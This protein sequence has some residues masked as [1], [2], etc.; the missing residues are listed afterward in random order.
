MTQ[1]LCKSSGY[2]EFPDLFGGL[3][4]SISEEAFNLFGFSV[5]WYGLLIGIG[6]L[7]CVAL[8][9]RSCRRYGIE[10][11]DLLDYALFCLPAA[12]L[13]A[14]IY[15]VLFQWNAFK[16]DLVRVFYIWEGGL[17]VYGGILAAVLAA[18]LVS[19]YKKKSFLKLV[20][21]AAPYI[22]LG[23]AIGRWGNFFNQEAYGGATTLPWGMTGNQIAVENIY[24]GWRADTLVHP[25][26]LY[27]SLWCFLGFALIM[28]YRRSKYKKVDGECICLYMVLYGVERT[29]VEGLRTDSLYI[30]STGIRV[31]QLLSIVLV[32]AGIALFIVL[33][34]RYNKKQA[35]EG[36]LD[37]EQ[38]TGFESVKERLDA[39]E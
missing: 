8:G 3:K 29:L 27:E 4:F 10:Q 16:D 39:E 12:I 19:R 18:F 9:M 13:G 32:L 7:L 11:D 2:V 5:R 6:V 17:A 35:L 14:R 28:L 24:R 20:D 23:Q 15:Y 25:T 1:L 30:G 22:L 38:K 37:P 34:M 21:F 33:R 31:S 36:A 26:F